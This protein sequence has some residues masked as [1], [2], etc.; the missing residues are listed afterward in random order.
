MRLTTRPRKSQAYVDFMNEWAAA[1]GDG[2]EITS[3]SALTAVPTT[4]GVL[5]F[6]GRLPAEHHDSER[7]ASYV[8]YSYATPIAWHVPDV[9]WIMPMQKYSQTTTQHQNHIQVTLE[10]YLGVTVD[11]I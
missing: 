10:N 2:I 7:Q 4:P 9:G 5:R 11:K 3:A 8:V 6:A 1:L